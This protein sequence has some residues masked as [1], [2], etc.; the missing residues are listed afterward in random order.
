MVSILDVLLDKSIFDVNNMNN[1]IIEFFE[2]HFTEI[3]RIKQSEILNSI[4]QIFNLYRKEKE[5]IIQL[6][7][8]T[9]LSKLIRLAATNRTEFNSSHF[10]DS[11]MYEPD[12]TINKE[13]KNLRKIPDDLQ[14]QSPF[15]RVISANFDILDRIQ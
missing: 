14:S 2:N 6:K 7:Y 9:N 4:N 1:N 10:S 15:W 12:S 5:G 13:S 3:K 8:I 11:T